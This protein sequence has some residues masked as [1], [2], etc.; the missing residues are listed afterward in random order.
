MEHGPIGHGLES[1]KQPVPI[2][3]FR[4]APAT[5]TAVPHDQSQWLDIQPQATAEE[6]LN[7]APNLFQ[8]IDQSTHLAKYAGREPRL[9]ID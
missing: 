7:T 4:P 1:A 9:T 5:E 8:G 2:L 6:R 3:I